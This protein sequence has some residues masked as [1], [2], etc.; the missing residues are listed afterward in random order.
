[1]TLPLTETGRFKI[2]ALTN[3]FSPPITVPDSK[4]LSGTL[5]HAPTLDEELSHLGLAKDLSR[6]RSLFDVYYESSAV[7]SRKPEPEFYKHALCGLGVHA[8]ETIFLDD[9]GPNLKAAQ[10]LGMRTIRMRLE[11]SL[12]ALEELE[13]YTSCRLIDDEDRKTERRRLAE[14]S[15]ARNSKL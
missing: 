11:S 15:A 5:K 7:G 10:R 9:I 8:E 13:R 3:N 6:I 4:S 12:P 1:M 2:A 14:L